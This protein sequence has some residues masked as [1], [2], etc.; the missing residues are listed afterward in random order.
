MPQIE[1]TAIQKSPSN[2]SGYFRGYP[3][4]LVGHTFFTEPPVYLQGSLP[5]NYTAEEISSQLNEINGKID[6]VDS[7]LNSA[8]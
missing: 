2:A 6:Q 4:A 1:A 8:L 7:K 3:E 5:A